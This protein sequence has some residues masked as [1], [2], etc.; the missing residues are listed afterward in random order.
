[1]MHT[2]EKNFWNFEIEYLGEIETEF[3]NT[4]LYQGPRW[5]QIMEK[6]RSKESRD[7][8]PLKKFTCK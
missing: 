6:Y 3:K 4:L 7:T 1:M 2:A 8:L 5:V